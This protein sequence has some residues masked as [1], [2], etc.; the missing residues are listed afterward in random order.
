MRI[1]VTGCNGSVGQRVV[2]RA[3]DDG[4]SVLG[5][6]AHPVAIDDISMRRS[7]EHEA[8]QFVQYDLRS[9]EGLLKHLEGCDAVVHLAAHRRPGDFLVQ[10]HNE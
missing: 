5:L 9:F 3:L 4:H 8:F 2:I 6:D 7:T 10:T 1:A